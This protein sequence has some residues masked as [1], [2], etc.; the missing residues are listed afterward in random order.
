M[1]AFGRIRTLKL[2]RIILDVHFI[3]A[4]P[5]NLREIK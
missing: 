5:L 2:R 3:L 4:R 1:T